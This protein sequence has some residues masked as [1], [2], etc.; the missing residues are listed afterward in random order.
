[1]VTLYG[2]ESS[3]VL[4]D[5]SYAT[6]DRTIFVYTLRFI[7]R[8][9]PN[10]IGLNYTLLSLPLPYSQHNLFTTVHKHYTTDEWKQFAADHPDVIQVGGGG[11]VV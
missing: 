4:Y 9:R 8:M 6:Y 3:Y 10:C 5:T 7:D 1:M 2:I 11:G